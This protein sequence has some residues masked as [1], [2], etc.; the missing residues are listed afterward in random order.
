[1]ESEV[2]R[3]NLYFSVFLLWRDVEGRRKW[4]KEDDEVEKEA[5]EK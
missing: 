5:M 2:V 1:V 3:R 4:A